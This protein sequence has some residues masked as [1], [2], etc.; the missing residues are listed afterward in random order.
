MLKAGAQATWK[1]WAGQRSAELTPQLVVRATRYLTTL[2]FAAGHIDHPA[3]CECS[4][5]Q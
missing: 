2:F 4:V 1:E 3:S 5:P